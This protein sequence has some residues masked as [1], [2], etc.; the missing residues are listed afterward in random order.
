MYR[1]FYNA[2]KFNQDLSAWNV[3]KVTLMDTLFNNTSMSI[4]NYN[5]LLKNRSNSHKKY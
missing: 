4:D 3:S 2:T 5:L 1:M